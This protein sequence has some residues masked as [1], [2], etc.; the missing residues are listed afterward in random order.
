MPC[1]MSCRVLKDPLQRSPRFV[2]S[3]GVI[4]YVSCHFIRLRPA[5]WFRHHSHV[6]SPHSSDRRRH[7]CVA[8]MSYMLLS[9]HPKTCSKTICLRAGVDEWTGAAAST[10]QYVRTGV[11]C[12]P[13][14]SNRGFGLISGSPIKHYGAVNARRRSDRSEVVPVIHS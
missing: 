3:M 14:I 12:P 11:G 5:P 7:A 1:Q 8:F 6:S 4:I 13:S 9:T 2:Y 10:E